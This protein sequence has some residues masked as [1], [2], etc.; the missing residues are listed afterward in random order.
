MNTL[1]G[2]RT[3]LAFLTFAVIVI[4]VGLLFTAC[5]VP[6]AAEMTKAP[7]QVPGNSVAPSAP[8]NVEPARSPSATTT[9]APTATLLPI[10]YNQ[11]PISD[12]IPDKKRNALLF[13][14]PGIAKLGYVP[15]ARPGASRCPQPDHVGLQT[16]AYIGE[17]SVI[18]GTFGERDHYYGLAMTNPKNC[19]YELVWAAPFVRGTL[20]LTESEHE[21]SMGTYSEPVGGVYGPNKKSVVDD[22]TVIAGCTG[23][24]SRPAEGTQVQ[25][26]VAI[27][28]DRPNGKATTY[29]LWIAPLSCPTPGRTTT[30]QKTPVPSNNPDVSAV[31]TQYAKTSDVFGGSK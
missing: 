21:S 20:S 5:S 10:D 4:S 27:R 18:V 14:E 3:R 9:P 2:N 1:T 8:Q 12:G 30:Q 6:A 25:V 31:Q 28:T 22:K 29:V 11:W 19:R 26:A 7:A 17:N 24:N 23:K 16:V 13:T 15:T